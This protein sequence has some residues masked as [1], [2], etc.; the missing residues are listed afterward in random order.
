MTTPRD[1]EAELAGAFLNFRQVWADASG[2]RWIGVAQLDFDHNFDEVRPYQV[3]LQYKGPLGKWNIRAGHYLLPF[4]LLTTYDTE[5]LVLRGLEE[6]NLGI[7]S[8]TGAQLFGRSGDFDYAL[9]VTGG[10]GNS[11]LFDSRARPLLATRVAYVREAWQVGLSAL[12]GRVWP[13]SN[14]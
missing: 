10:L 5:R 1:T 4:G 12:T 8:D 7:R 9:S 11:R 14:R 2:D 3:Y 13:G 6:T